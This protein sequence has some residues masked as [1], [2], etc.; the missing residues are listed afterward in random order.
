MEKCCEADEKIKISRISVP[1]LP[2]IIRLNYQ[3]QLN[4]ISMKKNST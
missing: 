3:L 1:N 2:E 4:I